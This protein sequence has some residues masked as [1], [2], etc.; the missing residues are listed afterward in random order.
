MKIAI[1]VII[2]VGLVYGGWREF[3]HQSNLTPAIVTP[4]TNVH[5]EFSGAP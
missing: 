4:Q 5:F 1:V 3:E 2:A